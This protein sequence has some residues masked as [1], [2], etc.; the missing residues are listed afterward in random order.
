MR[1]LLCLGLLGLSVGLNAA[2]IIGFESPEHLYLGNQVNLTFITPHAAP[3]S[4]PLPNGLALT[5]GQLVMFGGDFYGVP[6]LPISL[7]LTEADKIDRFN[8]AYVTL[9]NDAKAVVEVPQYLADIAL[10][11]KEIKDGLAQGKSLPDIYQDIGIDHLITQNCISGGFCPA[12]H[13]DMPRS[14]MRKVFVL[15]QGLALKLANTDYDHFNQQAWLSYL[16]GHSAALDY[17]IMAS[18]SQ[19]ETKLATAYAMNGFASHFLSD[20]FAA[21]HMRTPRYELS[22]HVTPMTVGSMLSNYMH[23]EDNAQGLRVS[24]A[25]GNT[26]MSYGDTFYA[27]AQDEAN[28]QMI[29]KALQTSADEIFEAFTTGKKPQDSVLPLIPDL[30]QLHQ[31]P[32][33]ENTSPLF[34]WDEKVQKLLRRNNINNLY[35]YSHTSSWL[36]WSTLIE[37]A[38]ARGLPSVDQALL[39]ADPQTRTMALQ[40][41]LITDKDL[42]KTSG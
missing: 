12:D 21:G 34:Y 25:A 31:Y 37:L 26:W 18:A 19:D 29:L 24:N 30:N 33:T 1:V 39:L 9:A 20:L 16:A 11:D 14:V 7:G 40:L 27:A 41:N 32:Q 23:N 5:Y 36:G 8:K 2:P 17:A 4:L 28:A 6:A 42:L 38:T 13:P 3:V 10:E 35:D 22:A 15:N